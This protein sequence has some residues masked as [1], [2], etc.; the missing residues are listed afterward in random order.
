VSEADRTR[1]EQAASNL[2]GFDAL[3]PGQAETMVAMEQG[4]DVLTIL[5]TGGGKSLCYQLPALMQARGTTLVISPL[6][7]LMKDQVDSLPPH[8]RR[9]AITIN[10]SLEG[11]EMHRRMEQ[12]AQGR[13]RLVYAA[14]ER[15]RQRPFLHILRQAPVNRLVIDEAHCVSLWGHDFRPDYLYIPEARHALG[16]PPLLAMTATAPPRVREDILQRLRRA[17]APEMVVITGDVFRRNLYFECVHAANQDEKLTQLLSIC[18]SE[19]GSGIVYVDTR[20]RAEN[21]AAALE[22]QGLSAGYYHAGIGDRR[23]RAAAQERFMEG[24]VRIMVATVAF[25]M[26]IDKAD[27]RF[28]VHYACPS[29][30]EAYY[31]EAGR[32]G[33]DR[34]PARCTLLYTSAD[35][36][37]L[38]RWSRRDML[39]VDALRRVY[40]AIAHR[41][42]G[43]ALGAIPIDDIARDVEMEPTGV[44][45]AIS[46]LEEAALFRRYADV[47]RT[48]VIR[49]LQEPDDR[50]DAGALSQFA[51]R[52]HLRRDHGRAAVPSCRPRP[53]AGASCEP[54]RRRGS[55]GSRGRGTTQPECPADRR[56][57]PL[58]QDERLSAPTYQ[59]VSRRRG[60]YPMRHV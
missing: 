25:G 9:K 38:T 60:D 19:S 23:A 59:P 46:L 20:A 6:I 7:A 13:Y 58:R 31:Q 37:R 56:D 43:R 26:G 8:M 42:N 4:R 14:P 49:L 1:L 32:A 40:A 18:Q 41:L 51:A 27:I 11:G 5:A 10:S 34:R 53:A 54:C 48:A 47:P 16:D 45:V 2:F 52:V 36:A 29:S 3:L 21:L 28:I 15:L 22:A 35:R 17:D 55:R 57:R 50:G 24:R 44:R 33:R 12:V 39:D 30:L